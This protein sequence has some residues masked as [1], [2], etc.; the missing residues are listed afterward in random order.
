MDKQELAEKLFLKRC[1]VEYNGSETKIYVSG[2]TPYRIIVD[3]MG[4]VEA[5]PI[6]GVAVLKDGR[7][8]IDNI[9][10][11]DPPPTKIDRLAFSI[12]KDCQSKEDGVC[13][14]PIGTCLQCRILR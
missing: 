1:H 10:Q 7:L 2:K 9:E 5:E 14:L 11:P 4:I 13:N 3:E 6:A 8:F 12:P